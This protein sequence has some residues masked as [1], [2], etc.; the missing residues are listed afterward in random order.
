MDMGGAE[1]LIMNIY[2]KIDRNKLQFDFAVHDK[3][4]G[5]F[6][7]EIIGLGGK[8]I[9]A[10]HFSLLSF[11]SYKKYWLSFLKENKNIY[12]AVH[13]H[14]SYSV[15]VVLS[16]AKK[17]GIKTIVHSHTTSSQKPVKNIFVKFLQRPIVKRADCL[18]A[19]NEHAGLWLYGRKG[20]ES[21]KFRVI[22]NAVDIEKFRFDSA[23]RKRIRQEIGAGED[24]LVLGNVARFGKEKNHAFLLEIFKEVKKLNANTKLLLVGGGELMPNIRV[25]AKESGYGDDIVFAGV[26]SDTQGY[27]SAMDAFVFPSHFEGFGI[28]MVEAQVNGLKCFAS[29]G[30]PKAADISGE[31]EFIELGKGAA[32]WAASILQGGQKRRDSR[33]YVKE[34][35]LVHLVEDMVKLYSSME[36]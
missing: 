5:Y 10:P 19:C 35:D 8:I 24:T 11:N 30:V 18:L 26:Q 14:I 22:N 2:R 31:S 9:Y 20:V 6:D 25:L 33:L 17:S 27:L 13:C 28:V 36:W 15:S 34:F 1:N 7:E 21:P 4:K 32:Y 3:D 16:A 23:A 29:G 12:S